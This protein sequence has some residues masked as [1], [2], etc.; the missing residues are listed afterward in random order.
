MATTLAPM[1]LST[2]CS[3]VGERIGHALHAHEAR[4]LDEHGAAGRNDLGQR[5][6]TIVD[7]GE[8]LF[9]GSADEVVTRE[10][11]D[12]DEAH[13]GGGAVLADVRW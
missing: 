5:L 4:G 11:A 13:A 8:P 10:V 6:Q 7:G 12:G 3:P 2:R 9:A 1:A